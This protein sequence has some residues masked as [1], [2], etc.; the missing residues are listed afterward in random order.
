MTWE[1]SQ[2]RAINGKLS[3]KVTNTSQ[4]IS[5]GG[6][7]LSFQFLSMAMVPTKPNSTIQGPLVVVYL[8][9]SQ[10]SGKH[11]ACR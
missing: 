1:I 5:G 11:L 7:C 6:K 2:N 3:E 8:I 10:K 9:V 4:P